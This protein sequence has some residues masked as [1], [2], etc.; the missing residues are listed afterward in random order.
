MEDVDF[1]DEFCRFVQIHEEQHVVQRQADEAERAPEQQ[2]QAAARV[3]AEKTVQH[4]ASAKDWIER[5]H[6][7]AS[8]LRAARRTPAESAPIPG[9]AR[10][11]G[12]G[13]ARVS[14]S[15]SSTLGTWTCTKR[16]NSSEK[17][18]SSIGPF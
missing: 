15:A 3:A 13:T 14:S 8:Y 2:A 6:A 7:R 10:P 12:N 16:Q 4:E 9:R 11:P 5:S 18:T 17:S 1:S